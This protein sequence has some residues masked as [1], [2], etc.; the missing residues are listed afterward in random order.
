MSN[1]YNNKK[2]MDLHLKRAELKEYVFYFKQKYV[3]F[4]WYLIYLSQYL[5]VRWN[6]ELYLYPFH[7]RSQYRVFKVDYMKYVLYKTLV[8]T[9]FRFKTFDLLLPFSSLIFNCSHIKFK[10]VR[11][12]LDE[13]KRFFFIIDHI[14]NKHPITVKKLRLCDFLE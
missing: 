5:N 2:I 9:K 10:Q 4:T 12:F 13:N 7:W 1:Y 6:I 8:P 14:F 11:L 3:K